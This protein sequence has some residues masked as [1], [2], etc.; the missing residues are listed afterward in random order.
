[1][2]RN[3]SI[4]GIATAWLVMA[5]VGVAQPGSAVSSGAEVRSCYRVALEESPRWISSATWIEDS[6]RL[7][8]VDPHRDALLS[9]DPQGRSI[10]LP[11]NVTGIKGLLPAT[12][13]KAEDGFLLELVDGRFVGL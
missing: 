4:V 11:A 3:R 12:V 10:P 1:M 7:L 13:A 8:V 9:Y 5:L 2:S 6:S